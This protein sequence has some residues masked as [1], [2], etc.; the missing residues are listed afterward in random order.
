MLFGA[1]GLSSCAST[2]SDY[3]P[4]GERFAERPIDAKIDVYE[5][6]II[7]DRTYTVIGEVY[8][9][10]E[11]HL[12]SYKLE[13]AMPELKVQARRV[14]AHAIMSITEKRS[15]HLEA[16]LYIVSAKAIRYSDASE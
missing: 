5:G 9:S 13:N 8:V 6:D 4:S 11:A 16:G 3:L 15:R 14:G 1:L 12:R 2:Q 10:K 7:P